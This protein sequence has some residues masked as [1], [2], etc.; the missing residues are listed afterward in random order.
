MLESTPARIPLTNSSHKWT[1]ILFIILNY[2]LVIW[3]CNQSRIDI[4][5]QTNLYDVIT[6][7]HTRLCTT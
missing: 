4:N 7:D 5:S 1:R 3:I 2:K 6:L